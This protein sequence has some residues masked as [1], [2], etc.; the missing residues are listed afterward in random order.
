LEGWKVEATDLFIPPV[1]YRWFE[2]LK[3]S[4]AFANFSPRPGKSPFFKVKHPGYFI[5]SVIQGDFNFVAGK[6]NI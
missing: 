5:G 6:L 4:N 1:L 2:K 3:K